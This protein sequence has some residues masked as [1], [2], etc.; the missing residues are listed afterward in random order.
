MLQGIGM[1]L[2]K[3]HQMLSLMWPKFNQEC[4]TPIRFSNHLIV[5]LIVTYLELVYFWMA[6]TT[7]LTIMSLRCVQTMYQFKN[8]F[9]NGTQD[10]QLSFW[11]L[12]KS[13]TNWHT[14]NH[15]HTIDISFTICPLGNFGPAN[16]FRES[17]FESS[18][19]TRTLLVLASEGGLIMSAG[20]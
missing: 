17:E 5:H 6:R 12:G 4:T 20:N 16:Y 10:L 19:Y 14:N 18:K 7:S 11:S 8:N 15:K 1:D 3:L 9:P 2:Y 13:M